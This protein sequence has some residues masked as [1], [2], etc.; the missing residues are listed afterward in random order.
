[1]TKAYVR[2][3]GRSAA[4]GI[5]LWALILCAHAQVQT[6]LTDPQQ[7]EQQLLQKQ[8]LQELRSTMRQQQP[9]TVLN[10]AA[11]LPPATPSFT[12]PGNG[13]RRLSMEE[14]NELRRQ[15]A[16]D[17]RVAQVSKP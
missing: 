6:T 2:N 3:T 10:I 9:S 5:A 13:P 15:L 17:L 14:K 4:L 11:P 12:A 16:R 1:M 7:M 8:R